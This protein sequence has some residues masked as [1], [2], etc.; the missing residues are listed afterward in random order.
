[1]KKRKLKILIIDNRKLF[2]EGLKQAITENKYSEIV[3]TSENISQGYK[4]SKKF[5]PNVIIL[6]N[7]IKKRNTLIRKIKNEMPESKILLFFNQLTNEDIIKTIISGVDGYILETWSLSELFRG[8]QYL[9][10]E[11]I[12][13]PRSL[14]KHLIFEIKRKY[15]PFNLNQA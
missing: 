11:G 15:S 6:G 9:Q 2:S 4:L 12:L 5:Q 10:E 13:F 8:L 7:T 1:M 3:R 14:I